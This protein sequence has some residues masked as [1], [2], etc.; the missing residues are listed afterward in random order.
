MPPPRHKFQSYWSM[1][2]QTKDIFIFQYNKGPQL[3]CTQ[4]RKLKKIHILSHRSQLSMNLKS[5]MILILMKSLHI[6]QV[7]KTI[8][9]ICNRYPMLLL[10]PYF[11]PWKKEFPRPCLHVSFADRWVCAECTFK[12]GRE[13][14]LLFDRSRSHPC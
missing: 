3:Q 4:I 12:L 5:K 1:P 13:T 8:V 2:F 10:T 7:I 9:N 6:P 14:I 11:T